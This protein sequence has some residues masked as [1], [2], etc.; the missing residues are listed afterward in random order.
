MTD[1][2]YTPKHFRLGPD[3][4]W[5]GGGHFPDPY[6]FT[7]D[8]AIAVD[9]ALGIG[10]PLLVAGPPG[11]GKTMLADAMA[12]LLGAPPPLRHTFTSRSRLED[13]T[14]GVDQ[15]RRLHDA[16]LKEAGK[17]LRGEAHYLRAGVFWAAFEPDSAAE[18]GFQAPGWHAAEAAGNERHLLVLLDEV[19][20]AEP[21]LPND[22]L[23]VL[24][25][26]R[27]DVPG[28]PPV[29]APD[30]RRLQVVI[31]T[32][33]ER[34]LAPAFVRR[35]VVLTLGAPTREQLVAIGTR[36]LSK[37]GKEVAAATIAA[38]ADKT[39]ALVG[40]AESKGLRAPGTSEF[41]DALDACVDL[42]IDPDDTVWRMIE[43]A[44]LRK[45]LHDF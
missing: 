7:D 21:D 45:N 41:L 30:G 18:R 11:C 40:E 23:D 34:E 31:T 35:C 9:V 26:R 17:E 33:G 22:L 29:Q 3:H 36:R 8:I 13:L 10:R 44:T 16:Q 24:D 4:T 43:R 6:L 2:P 20:K 25:R 15:L 28:R 38:V 27:F 37:Q 14:G 32:N 12:G 42:G 39:L 19:D 5:P 1:L